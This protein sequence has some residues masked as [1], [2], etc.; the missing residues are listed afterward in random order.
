M[1]IRNGFVSN[2]SS[3]SFVIA[4]IKMLYNDLTEEQREELYDDGDLIVASGPD[5][6]VPKGFII[7]G[8]PIADVESDNSYLDFSEHSLE[9]IGKMIFDV[10][11]KTGLKGVPGVYTGT[12][13]C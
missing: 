2:S 4:G 13:S 6:G 1:K 7:I 11:E 3:S 12:R 10:E 8:T 9:D 5:D